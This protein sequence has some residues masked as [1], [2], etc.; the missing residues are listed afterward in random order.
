MIN[1]NGEP[2]IADFGLTLV[3]DVTYG[4][5]TA[6]SSRGTSGWMS[7]ERINQGEEC[8]D[9]TAA[10]DVWAYGLLCFMVGPNL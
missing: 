5:F 6:T 2:V 10:M 7:P 4:R 8:R 9:R 1:E 3:G